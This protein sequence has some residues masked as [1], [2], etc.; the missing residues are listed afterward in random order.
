MGPLAAAKRLAAAHAEKVTAC[1][2]ELE[3]VPSCQIWARPV[4]LHSGNRHARGSGKHVRWSLRA[5]RDA[6]ECMRL[7]HTQMEVLKIYSNP[8][9]S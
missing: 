4:R 5:K 9:N 8:E 7:S 6:Y 3:P 1:S 2:V